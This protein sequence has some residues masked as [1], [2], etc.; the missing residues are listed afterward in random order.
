MEDCIFCR[1]AN[2]EIPCSKVYEDDRVMAFLDANPVAPTHVLVIPKKHI[3]DITELSEGDMEYVLAA[4]RAIQS[5]VRDMGLA[6][7]FR[8]VVNTGSS[9]GQT[10]PHLHYHILGGREMAWPPG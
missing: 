7:G 6:E 4:T 1:I 3:Q 10:V 5:I 9:G 8:V 2:D